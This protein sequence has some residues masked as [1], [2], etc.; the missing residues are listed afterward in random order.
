MTISYPLSLP[1]ALS[2]DGFSWTNFNSVGMLV[3]QKLKAAIDDNDGKEGG[4]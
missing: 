1:T 3:L 4:G 2:R